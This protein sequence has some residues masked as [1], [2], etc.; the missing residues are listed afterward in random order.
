MSLK[1]ILLILLVYSVY[2]CK[3]ENKEKTLQNKVN[4]SISKQKKMINRK[5]DS[6]LKQEKITKRKNDSTI[7][8]E[9]EKV[10]G[11]IEF[12]M[13]EKEG[14]KEISKF[15]ES[16]KK[17]KYSN[18][19]L[20]YS[21]IGNFE[22]STTKGFYYEDKLH[23]FK[24]MGVS[25]PWVDYSQRIEQEYNNIRKILQLRY[26]E[27][28]NTTS[29]PKSYELEGKTNYTLDSWT[30]GDKKIR[31][32]IDN[33]RTYYSIDILIFKPKISRII[34]YYNTLE[35]SAEIEKGKNAFK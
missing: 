16:S 22:F 34:N 25:I 8:I 29:F 10:I 6:I 7:K 5:N 28:N 11:N 17:R 14:E 3:I 15:T 2:G 30:I 23:M 27:P 1:K 18:S 19:D 4:D 35:R 9:Q 21:F 26:G 13:S 20:K 12:G 31:I 33:S 32:F 24:I